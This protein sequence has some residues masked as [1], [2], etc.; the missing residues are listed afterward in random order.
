[1]DNINRGDLM[2][3]FNGWIASILIAV[4]LA[5]IAILVVRATRQLVANQQAEVA[6][7]HAVAETAAEAA[8]CCKLAELNTKLATAQRAHARN[9]EELAIL[10]SRKV[11]SKLDRYDIRECEDHIATYAE[12]VRIYTEQIATLS[13]PA[14][15]ELSVV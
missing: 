8:R 11:L 5:I 13:S 6:T 7:K 9:V 14:Q 10:T 1:V 3:V 12:R 15:P 4:A 2:F